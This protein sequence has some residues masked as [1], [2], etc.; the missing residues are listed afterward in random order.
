[1]ET[2][3]Y[4]SVT[5]AGYNFS[6]HVAFHSIPPFY[7]WL[8]LK[9]LNTYN[10]LMAYVGVINSASVIRMQTMTY[11]V[12]SSTLARDVIMTSSAGAPATVLTV[13]DRL[14]GRVC[15]LRSNSLTKMNAVAS[16][17]VQLSTM[18]SVQQCL[19]HSS[20]ARDFY[21]SQKP[22]DWCRRPHGRWGRLLK[23]YNVISL[24][25]ATA[26]AYQLSSLR[27]RRRV[28]GVGGLRLREASA[29]GEAVLSA[30]QRAAWAE[31][32]P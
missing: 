26:A 13:D 3:L 14:R 8:R 9:Y 31:I 20:V 10:Q 15:E 17:E 19:F 11:N 18:P 28:A 12:T 1:M 25:P 4:S 21:K 22:G 27:E 30:V 2:G 7:S 16:N 5:A 29:S 24:T 6:N 32:S 23:R